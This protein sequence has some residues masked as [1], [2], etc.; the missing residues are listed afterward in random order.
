[1]LLIVPLFFRKCLTLMMISYSFD[2][3]NN[4]KNLEVIIS[5]N[6]G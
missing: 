2:A 5:P 6:I 3:Q 4:P 1:M